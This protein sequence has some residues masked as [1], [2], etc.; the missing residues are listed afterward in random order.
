[1]KVRG[2][3]LLDIMQKS[4]SRAGVLAASLDSM[5]EELPIRHR[6][7]M[8]VLQCCKTQEPGQAPVHAVTAQR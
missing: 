2:R 3:R 5:T 8:V 1:M 7:I 6:V 4:I